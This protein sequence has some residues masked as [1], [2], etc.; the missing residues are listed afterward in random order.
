MPIVRLDTT[1]FVDIKTILATRKGHARRCLLSRQAG[2]P[3]MKLEE[4]WRKT[5]M[6]SE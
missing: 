1:H 4:T 3:F 2:S 6:F 5:R